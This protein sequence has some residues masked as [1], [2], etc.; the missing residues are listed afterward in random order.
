MTYRRNSINSSFLF[1][2]SLFSFS[3]SD[4]TPFSSYRGQALKGATPRL[5]EYKSFLSPWFKPGKALP[6]CGWRTGLLSRGGAVPFSAALAPRGASLLKSHGPELFDPQLGTPTRR[7]V[8]GCRYAG[9]F[10]F[11]I[12]GSGAQC[13]RLRRR[14]AFAPKLCA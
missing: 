14:H 13:A 11:E 10:G 4:G 8:F 7:F 6:L 1:F 12:R 9:A 2:S 5:A 3:A